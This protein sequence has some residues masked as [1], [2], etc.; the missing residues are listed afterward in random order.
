MAILNSARMTHLDRREAGSI[1]SQREEFSQ[2]DRPYEVP[3]ALEFT[4]DTSG[5]SVDACVDALLA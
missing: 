4:V 5:S 2:I 1:Y 3:E